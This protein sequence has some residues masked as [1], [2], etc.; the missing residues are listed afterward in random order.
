MSILLSFS[1]EN[2]LLC[3]RILKHHTA[4]FFRYEL[5]DGISYL[6]IFVDSNQEWRPTICCSDYKPDYKVQVEIVGG[7]T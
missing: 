6:S 7:T 4:K 2:I 5:V 3:I 1:D